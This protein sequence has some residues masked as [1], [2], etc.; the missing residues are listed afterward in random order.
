[1]N[2]KR[3]IPFVLA[4]FALLILP[5][6]GFAQITSNL[7]VG[8]RG[9]QVTE[10]QT[11]LAND[12]ALYPQGIVS[13]YYGN[14]TREAVMRF[15]AKYGIQQTG[16]IGPITRAKL[17]ELLGNGGGGTAG[18]VSAPTIGAATVSGISANS[19][20]IS[21]TT[22]ESARHRVMYGTTW[23]FLYASAPSALD[24]TVDS[25]ASVTLSGLSPNTQY[26]YVQESIDASGNVMWTVSNTFRT[27]Q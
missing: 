24:A 27:N 23:P 19:A 18:D 20:T 2:I 11:Y 10:V 16:T 25:S 14:L 9:A 3:R 4:A 13:G 17:N 1:M 8:S 12:P 22:S 5:A 21:W 15:Q 7:S 26:Y 6:A